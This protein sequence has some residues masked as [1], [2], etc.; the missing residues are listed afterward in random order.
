MV[1]H[2]SFTVRKMQNVDGYLTIR[3]QDEND[4]ALKSPTQG[5]RN[6]AGE[7]AIFRSFKPAFADAVYQD[8][9][10][11]LP[12]GEIKLPGG[13]HDLKIDAD[14]IY[15]NGDFIQH[16]TLHAFLLTQPESSEAANVQ[17]NQLWIDNNFTR[18]GQLGMLIHV[19]LA[20]RQLK[21]IPS[22]LAVAVEFKNGDKV[23]A[24]NP[25]Y[26]ST[27]GQLTVYRTLNNRFD[28]SLYTDLEVFIPYREFSVGAGN[29]EL[30]LHADIL[31]GDG[32]NLHVTY[33]DFNFTK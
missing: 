16:L 15:E 33:Y 28:N 14:L 27:N 1:I 22:K 18:D 29:Q 17:F 20:L 12:Y 5:F 24:S 6:K 7:L 9:S 32:G 4:E 19:N 8:L 10:V 31:Y 23:F 25:E 21:D 3:I 26:R 30:R 11:F 13:K 2:T